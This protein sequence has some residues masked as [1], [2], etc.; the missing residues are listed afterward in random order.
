MTSRPSVLLLADES[1]FSYRVLKAAHGAG[2]SVHVLAGPRASLLHLSRYSASITTRKDS[3]EKA[4]QV[5]G[6]IN[7]LAERKSAAWV[8]PSDPK[9]TRFLIAVA[10]RLNRPIFPSPDLATFDRLNDKWTFTTTMGDLGLS[11][12]K[13]RYFA[14]KEELLRAYEAAE[15]PGPGIVKPLSESG[16]VGVQRV[17]EEDGPRIAKSLT[18]APII[19][20]EFIAGVDVDV[21]A[22]CRDG[23]LVC[24]ST[25]RRT[26]GK[27]LLQD[28]GELRRQTAALARSQNLTGIFDFDVVADPTFTRVHWIECNP[29]VFF[30]I[31]FMAYGGMNLIAEGLGLKGGS[32]LRPLDQRDERSCLAP[33]MSGP[34]IHVRKLRA[35]LRG[36]LHAE[37][38]TVRDVLI[39]GREFSDP[40]LYF[41]TRTAELW[42]AGQTRWLRLSARGLAS[43]LG[44][45]PVSTAGV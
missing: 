22:F 34:I 20:Q 33:G 9:T 1:D 7:R 18:Y 42:K 21:T 39:F 10:A 37:P 41:R 28:H 3:L 11:C 29:R 16:G 26:H 38:V 6:E 14:D 35:V 30:A 19:W 44:K 12:P 40:V 32:R 4:D 24:F 2:L 15:L 8:L 13:S 5:V 43:R 45:P 25:R 31:D 27:F 23:E 17:A 36:L